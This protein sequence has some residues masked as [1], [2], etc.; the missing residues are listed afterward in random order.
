MR[1]S[2]EKELASKAPLQGSVGDGD[3]DDNKAMFA[4]LLHRYKDYGDLGSRHA[5]AAIVVARSPSVHGSPETYEILGW[6]QAY[7]SHL[8]HCRRQ[9]HFIQCQF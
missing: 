2:W 8:P 6:S 5:L 1:G 4:G 9:Q 3:W 7:D